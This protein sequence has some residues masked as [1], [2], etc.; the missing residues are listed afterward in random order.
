MHVLMIRNHGEDKKRL[1]KGQG[2][3][4]ENLGHSQQEEA[5]SNSTSSPAWRTGPVYTK[6]NT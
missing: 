5:K 3:K 1:D 4:E 2:D 6:A